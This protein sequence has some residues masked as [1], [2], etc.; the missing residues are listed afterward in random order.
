MALTLQRRSRLEALSDITLALGVQGSSEIA[1][2]GVVAA[3]LRAICEA[4]GLRERS[5]VH[6]T[7]LV[8]AVLRNVVG[9]VERSSDARTTIHAVLDS[10]ET[11]GD[12][13]RSGGGYWH[14]TPAR[15]VCVPSG[16]A[17][18]LGAH[19]LQP[20]LFIAQ[21]VVRFAAK[22][23]PP[24]TPVQGI[25]DWLGHEDPIE[26]WTSRALRHYENRLQ[27]SGMPADHLQI[28]APD[29]GRRLSRSSWVDAAEFTV[30][31]TELRLCR[32]SETKAAIYS[33]PYYLGEFG[34]DA[35]GVRLLR[36]A[37]VA[38]D[39][40]RRFRFGFDDRLSARRLLRPRRQGAT[41]HLTIANDLPVA[42]QRVLALGW[43]VE[44][45]SSPA[46]RHL[47]FPVRAMPFL[48]R[49]LARLGVLI[50]GESR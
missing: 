31:A 40:A 33:R 35:A 42:E 24:N 4:Y 41:V 20:A 13:S 11:T 5:G 48:V 28:Y 27:Q 3:Q 38:H 45:G 10:L 7:R 47:T 12:L 46:V 21:G 29:Q 39:H 26:V 43:P 34:R 8:E 16:E 9:L 44:G 15:A 25:E 17:L 36:A 49:A 23:L 2:V 32:A 37:P 30:A 18:L 14:A 50:E 6:T 1:E 19:S 22:G